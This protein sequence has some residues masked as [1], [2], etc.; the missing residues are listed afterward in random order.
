MQ[1]QLA[2]RIVFNRHVFF[3]VPRYLADSLVGR[4]QTLLH[5]RNATRIQLKISFKMNAFSG[6]RERERENA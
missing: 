5:T 6:E 4:S 2:A 3:L 1:F